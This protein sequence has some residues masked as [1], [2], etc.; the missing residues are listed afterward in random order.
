MTNAEEILWN[1]IRRDSLGVRFR[2]QY[3]IGK[4]IAD[5]YCPQKKLVVELDGC[6]HYTPQGLEYD[7][8]RE[9]YMSTFGI[10]TIRF[11]NRDVLT[12]IEGVLQSL[13]EAISKRNE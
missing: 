9:D 4:Y 2:R 7:R 12:N 6:Q 11:S 10:K 1:Y 5:F 13:V 3:G 8:K